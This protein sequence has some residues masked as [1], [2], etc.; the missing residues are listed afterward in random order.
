MKYGID[1][2]SDDL[3]L[4]AEIDGITDSTVYSKEIKLVLL[5][6]LGQIH[7]CEPDGYYAWDRIK[8]LTDE[9]T[10]G[11]IAFISGLSSME[12][13]APETLQRIYDDLTKKKILS[14]VRIDGIEK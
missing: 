9:E 7:F 11:A 5:F 12:P 14:D 8:A 2:T 4:Q 1:Y 6:L 13:P 3:Y 10:A